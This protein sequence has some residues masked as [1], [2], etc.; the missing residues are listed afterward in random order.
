MVAIVYTCLVSA[1][2]LFVVVFR[3]KWELYVDKEN[4]FWRKH[5][6]LSE[7][8]SETCGAWEKSI[9]FKAVLFLGVL[10]GFCS[11]YIHEIGQFIL[12]D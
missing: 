6:V 8:A 3:K 1:F 7:R 4:E 11:I 2:F 12:S 9:W 5:G 10:V